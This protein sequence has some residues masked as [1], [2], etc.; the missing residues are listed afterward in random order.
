MLAASILMGEQVPATAHFQEGLAALQ[1]GEMAQAEVYI[2]AG[3]ATDPHAAAGYDLLGIALDAQ[4]KV[5]AAEEAFRKAI[6]LNPR[7]IPA[8]NKSGPQPVPTVAGRACQGT[9]SRSVETGSGEFY[10]QLQPG[11]DRARFQAVRRCRALSECRASGQ[12]F[13]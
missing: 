3:L 2:R 5:S 11:T 12:A 1:K 8:Y 13:R 7:L 4:G 10:S 9:V 6:R